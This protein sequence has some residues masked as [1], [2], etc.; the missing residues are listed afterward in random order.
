MRVTLLPAAGRSPHPCACLFLGQENQE[1]REGKPEMASLTF[2][3]E[4]GVSKKPLG[5]P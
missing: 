4:A 5:L 2:Q 3:V 1:R